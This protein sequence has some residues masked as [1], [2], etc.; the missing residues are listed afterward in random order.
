MKLQYENIILRQAENKD[1]A[2]LTSWW[3]DGSVMAHA[4]FP[5]GLGLTEEQVRDKIFEG[6]CIIEVIENTDGIIK[7]VP[8]GECHYRDDGN[9]V[10]AIGIKICLPSYQNRGIGR[11]VLSLLITYVF[12][13]GY[14]K[15]VLNTNLNNTRAQHVYESLG[16][17]KVRTNL[18][19]WTDQ[20]GSLQSF[21]D[22]ELVQGNFISRIPGRQVV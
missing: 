6:L 11:K 7:T 22:Y 9:T 12:Q 4:G 19:C 2:Q 16:F 10:A 1:A 3:N 13:N 18:D 17:R 21:V 20:L 8:I 14:T 15:I 5:K